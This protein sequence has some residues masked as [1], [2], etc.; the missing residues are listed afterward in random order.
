MG[1]AADRFDWE[2]VSMGRQMNEWVANFSHALMVL[3]A[4]AVGSILLTALDRRPPFRLIPTDPV[5]IRAGSFVSLSVPVWRDKSRSCDATYS[6]YLF[7][8]R[9]YRVDLGDAKASAETIRK[10]EAES[11]G[12][13][14]IKFPVPPIHSSKDDGGVVAGPGSVDADIEYVCW[15]GHYLWP[16]SVRTSVPVVIVP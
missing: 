5:T 1:L 2:A 12:R 13:M 16:I 10:L 9:G 7:D 3:A 8:A 11:P 15:K 14:L 4:L 6:R